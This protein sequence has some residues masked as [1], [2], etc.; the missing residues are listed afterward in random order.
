MLVWS[1]GVLLVSLL[2]VY[3]RRVIDT[4]IQTAGFNQEDHHPL[5][6]DGLLD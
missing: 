6:D 3:W 5:G 2:V 4:L 1:V